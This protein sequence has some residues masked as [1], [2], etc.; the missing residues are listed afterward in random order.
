MRRTQLDIAGF[1]DGGKG[2]G[3]KKEGLETLENAAEQPPLE[4]PE[5]N[6]ALST[7]LLCLSPVRPVRLLTSRTVINFCDFK[8]L[9]LW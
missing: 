9:H 5:G 8:P 1:E 6:A 7:P 3:P 2:Q 4:P